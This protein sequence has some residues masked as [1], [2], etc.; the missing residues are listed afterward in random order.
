MVKPGDELIWDK[1]V[2][3]KD[4]DWNMFGKIDHVYYLNRL[5]D[6]HEK[7]TVKEVNNNYYTLIDGFCY[8]KKLF[9]PKQKTYSIW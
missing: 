5:L 1:S 8:P 9:R 2:K 4:S 6:R 7:I 3:V